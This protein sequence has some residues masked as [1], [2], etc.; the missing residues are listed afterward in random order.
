MELPLNPE[1]VLRALRAKD[2]KPLSDE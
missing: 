1:T 2:N